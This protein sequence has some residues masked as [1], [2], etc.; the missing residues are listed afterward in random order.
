MRLTNQDN[1]YWRWWWCEDK[2]PGTPVELFA[3]A[4]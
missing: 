2:A 4:L 1:G 3:A